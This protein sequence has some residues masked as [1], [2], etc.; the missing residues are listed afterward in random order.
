M[1]FLHAN[2]FECISGLPIIEHL[3]CKIE[4]HSRC[5]KCTECKKIIHYIVI[6]GDKKTS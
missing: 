2:K 4:G 5:E 1:T 3:D 6:E